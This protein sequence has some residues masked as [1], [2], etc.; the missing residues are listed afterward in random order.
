MP[1]PRTDI[2]RVITSPEP[3]EGELHRSSETMKALVTI[4]A[5][6]P[7]FLACRLP[8]A[9]AAADQ[10]EL[11]MSKGDKIVSSQRLTREPSGSRRVTV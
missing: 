9:A 7:V 4:S 10:L 11:V 1:I 5:C 6:I 2:L 8:V 3:T